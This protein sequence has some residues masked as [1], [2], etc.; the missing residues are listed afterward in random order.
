MKSYLVITGASRGIGY[1]CAREF[2]KGGWQVINISRTACDIPGVTNIL[3]DLADPNWD[4]QIGDELAPLAN[5]EKICLVHNASFCHGDSAK[6]LSA[7]RLRSVLDINLMAPVMLNGLCLPQ[8]KAGSSIIYVGSTLAEKAIPGLASYIISKHGLAGLMKSTCQ[9]LASTQIHTCCVCPGITDTS[10]LAGRFAAD[11]S[12][13]PIL[14]KKQTMDRLV[15]PE[16]IADLIWFCANHPV[17]NGAM[18]HASLGQRE[19]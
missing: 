19:S 5:A 15:E 8:M 2:I 18:I 11:P 6:T 3:R 12:L 17:V 7:E 14:E 4:V 13:R 9:D 16:E 1:A 10:M